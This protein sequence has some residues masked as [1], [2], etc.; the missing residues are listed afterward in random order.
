MPEW[1]YDASHIKL[2]HSIEYDGVD[3]RH[4]SLGT[5]AIVLLLLYL[6]VDQHETIPPIADQPEENLGPASIYND[7]AR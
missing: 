7:L 2:S 6:G 5:H 3:I 1:L 4:L